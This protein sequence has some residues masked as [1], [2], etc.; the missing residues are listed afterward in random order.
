MNQ[1]TT[2]F[3]RLKPRSLEIA[4]GDLIGVLRSLKL[5]GAQVEGMANKPG[6]SGWRLTIHWPKVQQEV[7][8]DRIH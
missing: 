1:Q 5:R 4:N 3:D 6:N 7:N 2:L 8:H